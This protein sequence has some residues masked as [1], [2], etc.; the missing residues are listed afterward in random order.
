MKKLYYLIYLIV[1]I[2]LILEIG[3]RTTKLV[4]PG[5]YQFYRQFELV[6]SLFQYQNYTTDEQ[7]IYKFSNWITDSIEANFDLEKFTSS[8]NDFSQSIRNEKLVK[9]IHWEVD[10]LEST[11]SD[12]KKLE[13]GL[14]GAIDYEIQ[15]FVHFYQGILRKQTLNQ[16]DILI[17]NYVEQPFNQE[18]FRSISFDS[19]QSNKIKV[20]LIGDS[21][22]YGQSA[23]PL[24][25]SFADILLTKNYLVYNTGISGTDPAQ[26]AAIAQKY[27]PIIKPDIVIVNFCTYNDMM[28]FYRVPAEDKPHEYITNAGFYISH[29]MGKFYNMEEAYSFYKKLS[30]IPQTTILNKIMSKSSLLT[31]VWSILN[32][33][34][35]IHHPMDG[36]FEEEIV[37]EEEQ[38]LITLSYLD[39][40]TAIGNQ[41]NIPVVH[42]FLPDLNMNTGNE[43]SF[44]VND[45]NTINTLIGKITTY[46][47]NIFLIA[48]LISD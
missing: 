4:K 31:F 32:K 22:T 5:V 7:G 25:N 9:N 11:L 3:L 39:A 14:V 12:F 1:F 35:I 48:N 20:L 38:I 36:Y 41:Y 15:D 44:I 19:I 24:Y 26:Y 23:K 8:P 13:L 27:I 34:G 21:F 42:S 2:T 33:I 43:K 37:L 40:I 6:D 47:P 28:N 30:T 45:N 29:T 46:T 18:G 17:L 16:A 10:D